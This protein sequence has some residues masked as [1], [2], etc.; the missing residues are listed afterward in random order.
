M[1]PLDNEFVQ[2]I[3]QIIED[4]LEMEKMD[5]AFI[6]DQMCMSHS[7][8]YRKIKGVADMSANEVHPQGENEER[9]QTTALRKILHIR[10]FLHDGVQQC[11][12]LQTMLQE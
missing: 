7:T 9:G 6:A 3:T 8:L 1:N 4:N 11:S 2:R 10:D 12:L 5:I